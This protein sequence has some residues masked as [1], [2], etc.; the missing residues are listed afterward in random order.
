MKKYLTSINTPAGSRTWKMIEAAD[1]ERAA[2]S[3]REVA[4]TEPGLRNQVLRI[5]VY[6]RRETV[7]PEAPTEWVAIWGLVDDLKKLHS[8]NL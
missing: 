3:A 6:D 2:H 4:K 8:G 5:T 1:H 7:D